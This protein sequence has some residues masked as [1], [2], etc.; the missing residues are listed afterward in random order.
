[1]GAIAGLLLTAVNNLVLARHFGAAEAS[2]SFWTVFLGKLLLVP[3]VMA[4]I[5]WGFV[6][7]RKPSRGPARRG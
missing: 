3:S 4:S 1:V 5:V 7:L 2:Y 6:F